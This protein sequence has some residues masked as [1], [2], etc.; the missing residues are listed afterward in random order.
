MRR[1]YSLSCPPLSPPESGEVEAGVSN[2]PDTTGLEGPVTLAHPPSSPSEDLP[3]SI[4][5]KFFLSFP[6]L[7]YLWPHHTLTENIL[8]T[9]QQLPY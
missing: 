5:A 1:W 3:P 9:L 6:F 4:P 8:R 7:L 2:C